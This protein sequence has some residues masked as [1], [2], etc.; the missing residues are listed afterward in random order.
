[1]LFVNGKIYTMDFQNHTEEAMIVRDGLISAV[2]SSQSIMEECLS[3]EEI[4][5][6]EGKAVLPGFNDSHMHLLSY[7]YSKEIVFLDNCRSIEELVKKVKDFIVDNHIPKGRWVEGRGW[8]ETYFPERRMPDR[9]DLDRISKDHMI[10]LGRTCSFACVTN[11]KTL[12]ELNLYDQQPNIEGGAINADEAGISTGVFIG[13]ACQLIYDRMPKLG[14]ERIKS[15]ILKACED[16]KRAGI[17]SVET[18]DFELVRA[19]SF[20]DILQA[21]FELD[22][23]NK[24]PVRINEML[25]L[26]E[27]SQLR[28]FLKLGLRTGDGSPFFKI[29]HFKLVMDGSLGTRSAA[30]LQQYSDAPGCMGDAYYSQEKLNFLV[31]LAYQN[32]LTTV[33]DG[34]GDRGIRMALEAY[35]PI[36]EEN[37]NDD[38]RFCIDHSQITTEGII[39]EYSR[40]GV[41]GGL[42]LI[43][44]ASDISMA[45]NR[46]GT[47]RAEMSYNWK[48]FIDNNVV[49]AAGSDSPV[50]DY[51]PIMGIYA[52][53]NRVDREGN[54]EGGWLPGQKIS[55]EQAVRAYTT[56]AAYATFEE[57]IKG[58][59]EAGKY[60]DAVVLS[61]DIFLIDPKEIKDVFVEKTIVNGHIIFDRSKTNNII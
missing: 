17:T 13:E 19:G 24:L 10:A 35:K 52:A 15:T 42:E 59:L 56:G 31:R 48:R 49:I 41:T 6:L 2:G 5:D 7:G 4:I 25:Y 33:C 61:Q 34:I 14:V 57:S 22:A 36:V 50:E 60:A 29:G 58:S 30:L 1:M 16:Y 40:L 45:P 44:V 46:V 26:P 11:T 21:Y 28:D 54:P 8:N 20:H 18:D 43:F 27:E 9:F 12:K 38:L 37:P 53:V 51:N 3:D 23:D 55:V 39:E 47:A 32:G